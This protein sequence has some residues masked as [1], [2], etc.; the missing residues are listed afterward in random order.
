M[1]EA[2][3]KVGGSL[4]EDPASLRSLCKELE[5]LARKHRIL[6]VPGGG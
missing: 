4:A 2:V 1:V 5:R 6:V 3:V